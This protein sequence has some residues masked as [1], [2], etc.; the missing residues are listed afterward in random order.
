MIEQIPYEL[1]PKIFISL[2]PVTLGRSIPLV[3]KRF[4]T[5]S[6]PNREEI[7]S[8]WREMTRIHYFKMFKRLSHKKF[9]NWNELF[10]LCAYE[11]GV[12]TVQPLYS[13]PSSFHIK[14]HSKYDFTDGNARDRNRRTQNLIFWIQ[15]NDPANY[16][17]NRNALL[18]ESKSYTK[19][20]INY[21]VIF[22]EESLP[23]IG[24]RSPAVANINEDTIIEKIKIDI[25]NSPDLGT[26]YGHANKAMRLATIN[27]HL[28]VIIYCIE[29]IKISQDN[30]LCNGKTLLHFAAASGH[31]ECVK[32]FI[33]KGADPNEYKT[34]RS[35]ITKSALYFA[36]KNGHFAVVKYLGEE[37]K[38][39]LQ[40]EYRVINYAKRLRNKIASNH[41][42]YAAY[43]N[44]HLEI[45]EYL[46][47]ITPMI[48]AIPGI[49]LLIEAVNIGEIGLIKYLTKVE[50]PQD[51]LSN[52]YWQSVVNDY[53]KITLYLYNLLDEE[54]KKNIDMF[55]CYK[56]HYLVL[57]M[58]SLY[59]DNHRMLQ[60]ILLRRG[61]FF[62]ADS[63][64]SNYL[65]L[66][67]VISLPE[68]LRI[69]GKKKY[70]SY[71]EETFL[72]LGI[73]RNS[74]DCIMVLLN[75][76]ANP[77]L[78]NLKGELPIILAINNNLY[79]M[80]NALLQADADPFLFDSQGNNAII[81]TITLKKNDYYQLI[82][83]FIPSTLAKVKQVKKFFTECINKNNLWIIK[84]L[85]LEKDRPC[86]GVF[87]VAARELN[88]P[89]INQFMNEKGLQQATTQYSLRNS[90]ISTASTVYSTPVVEEVPSG[91]LMQDVGIFNRKRS[92]EK[93]P[94]ENAAKKQRLLRKYSP[95]IFSKQS[96]VI[97]LTL[98]YISES[99]DLPTASR[100]QSGSYTFPVLI[101]HKENYYYCGYNNNVLE[102]KAVNTFLISLQQLDFKKT[103]KISVS[104]YLFADLYAELKSLLSPRENTPEYP[105]R[106][107]FG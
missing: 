43:R 30:L 1:Y 3:S 5:L 12:V 98:L 37:A 40:Q 13:I 100:L 70:S 39:N 61:I 57:I 17:K 92:P 33:E 88:D 73:K 87:L 55:Y 18:F 52:A 99:Q 10:K 51:E 96:D 14:L 83:H 59:Y 82:F 42:V 103:Y 2:D 28:K 71:Q 85:L 44:G 105:S 34:T 32:Y 69:F 102:I 11:S 46:A 72:T 74:R 80:V 76:K 58:Y 64:F 94:E 50:Y 49:N 56:N 77:N 101:K 79:S 21:N 60:T 66:S 23:K 31:L 16:E 91:E 68:Q 63:Y 41:P 48:Q 7:N 78:S 4:N 75:N 35:S 65:D 62:T 29:V 15:E 53:D 25:N 38:V 84:Y 104:M 24:L 54:H 67:I 26:K 90:D 95:A 89:K 9:L 6:N 27:G 22:F 86:F 107:S 8:I 45:A 20:V 36:A 47:E 93:H 97:H 106:K 81:A 19:K